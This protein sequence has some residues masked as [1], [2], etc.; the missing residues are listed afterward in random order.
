[1]AIYK[2]GNKV[3]AKLTD[4]SQE[5]TLNDG[6]RIVF[7]C[8][9]SSEA[10]TIDYSNIKIDLDHTTFGTTFTEVVNF[11]TT[12]NSWISTMTDSFNE[13]DTKMDSV[14]ESTTKVNNDI[15]A[16]KMLIKMIMGLAT[17]RADLQANYSEE[18]YVNSLPEDAKAIYD[19]MKNDVLTSA[20]VDNFDF[21]TH[22]LIYIVSQ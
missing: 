19:E 17:N 7:W 14:I 8:N 4:L 5:A 9:S 12:A 20:G 18:Q 3:I 21:A 13:L 1:M 11:A 16:M 22:N 15:L 10:A 2:Q 6:D